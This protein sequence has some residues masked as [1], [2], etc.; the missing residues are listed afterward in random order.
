M[1][2]KTAFEQCDIQ[3]HEYFAISAELHDVPSYLSIADFGLN[4]MSKP[5]I[6]MSIKTV[7]YLAMGLPV[8]VNS[9]LLGGKELVDHYDIGLVVDLDHFNLDVVNNFIR[10]K[11]EE[12]SLKCRKLA[13]ENFS[14][15]KVARQYVEL[16]QSLTTKHQNNEG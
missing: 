7:E 10:N 12:I 15:E 9:N 6:R 13:Y 3:A 14:T 2:L 16:Y 8:I 4:F 1:E 11:N 5:D